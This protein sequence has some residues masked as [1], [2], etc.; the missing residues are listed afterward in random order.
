MRNKCLLFDTDPVYGILLEQPEL[1][2]TGKTISSEWDSESERALRSRGQFKQPYHWNNRILMD[3]KGLYEVGKY[4]GI[5]SMKTTKNS[6]LMDPVWDT[7]STS[8]YM[9]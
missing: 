7:G 9:I 6:R 8:L 2:E 5:P 3:I 1:T 4:P